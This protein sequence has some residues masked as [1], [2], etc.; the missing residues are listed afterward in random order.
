MKRLFFLLS[1]LLMIQTVSH[2]QVLIS[3]LL[4][5]KLNSDKLEFGLTTGVTLSQM[6]GV[7][8]DA[9]LP[10]FNLGFYFDIKMKNAWSFAPSCLMLAKM[11]GKGLASYPVGDPDMD[12]VLSKGSVNRQLAYIQL[13]LMLRYRLK[14]RIYFNAGPQVGLLRSAIDEFKVSSSQY[15]GTIDYD[16]AS[17]FKKLDAGA[18]TGIG[19]SL[20]EEKSMNFGLNYYYGLVDIQSGGDDSGYYNRAWYFYLTIPIGVS[21]GKK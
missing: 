18:T 6:D 11:G 2:G 15:E 5:D 13:P 4:G 17:G 7:A 1:C 9:N 16:I 10:T 12:A 3:L 20:R 14:N 19:F 8:H 21:K